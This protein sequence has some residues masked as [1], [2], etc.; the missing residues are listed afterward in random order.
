MK[1]ELI[2]ESGEKTTIYKQA[3][4]KHSQT[5]NK[6]F[7]N[8]LG[9]ETTL[10][11]EYGKQRSVVRRQAGRYYLLQSVFDPTMQQTL[12]AFDIRSISPGLESCTR[13][14][15][16]GKSKYGR[17]ILTKRGKAHLIGLFVEK[18]E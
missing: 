11:K 4:T 6:S 13:E 15:Y 5:L 12:C 14:N 18:L 9:E 16:L 17:N 8:D 3:A 7:L 10:A 2:T 1:K